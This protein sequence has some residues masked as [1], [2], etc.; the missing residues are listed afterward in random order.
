MT[1]SNNYINYYMSSVQ[2]L[3][4]GENPNSNALVGS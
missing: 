4:I 2:R 3:D 1:L